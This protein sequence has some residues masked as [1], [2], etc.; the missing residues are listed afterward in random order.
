MLCST[1][2]HTYG[3]NMYT[4]I[5]KGVG[6]GQFTTLFGS[7]SAYESSSPPHL[8]L[9]LSLS[10]SVNPLFS[11]KTFRNLC[12][13]GLIQWQETKTKF[14][15]CCSLY[16]QSTT[17]SVFCN[18][19]QCLVAT[20]IKIGFCCKVAYMVVISTYVLCV[21]FYTEV[22][23]FDRLHKTLHHRSCR[24]GHKNVVPVF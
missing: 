15:A 24:V 9:S 23:N 21:T 16:T 18:T 11:F 14:R 2:L 17:I 10:L 12:G 3:N 20:R 5:P 8:S 22:K 13:L 4:K 19:N 1:F 6:I 7:Q